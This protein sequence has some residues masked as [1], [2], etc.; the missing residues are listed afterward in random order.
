MPARSAGGVAGP[1]ACR[2]VPAARAAPSLCFGRIDRLS[3]IRTPGPAGPA[4]VKTTVLASGAVARIGCPPAT[5]VP[6]M[7]LF[8]F[9]SRA[10]VEGEDHVG[11]GERRAVRPGQVGAEVE[12]VRQAVG[13][14][15]PFF[16]QPGLH[17]EGR[18]VDPDQA[19]L[20]ELTDEVAGLIPF[21]QAVEGARLRANRADDLPSP[22]RGRRIRGRGPTRPA[23]VIEKGGR[24]DGS[25]QNPQQTGRTHSISSLSA[26]AL[27]A[28]AGP[29][30]FLRPGQNLGRRHTPPAG[31]LARTAT[32]LQCLKDPC[33]FQ[34]IPVQPASRLFVRA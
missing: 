15:L 12:R 17:L 1:Q 29:A 27:R 13:R 2:S 34:H 16:G 20:Q 8:T 33:R 25:D 11:G 26:F 19:A 9:G 18:A 24:H 31:G 3:R 30:S 4:K 5:M 21:Q 32:R 6:A 14:G 28:T 22:L 23:P 10:A 7:T